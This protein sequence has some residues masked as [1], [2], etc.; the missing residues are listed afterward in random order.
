M[1]SWNVSSIWDELMDLRTAFVEGMSRA[2]TFVAVVTTDGPGG[3]AG[4]T[5]SSLT[6]VS[7]DG[8]QP[9]LLACIHHLSPA[10]AAIMKNRAF[11]ANLLAEDQQP[12]SDLFAGRGGEDR[13]ARFDRV[14][15]QPGALGQPLLQGATVTFECRLATSLLWESHHIMVGRVAQVTLAE[16]PHALLYGQRGYRRAVG[17][18][19]EG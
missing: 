11:T 8:D 17:F 14:N 16:T 4:V 6:S 19:P 2:A 9:S 10:A 1:W 12:L 15:W 7:A 5:I 3:R 13:G 18:N